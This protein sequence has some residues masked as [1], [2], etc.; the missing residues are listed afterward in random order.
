MTHKDDEEGELL[1][2]APLDR[3][4]PT[5]RAYTV[6]YDVWVKTTIRNLGEQP[7]T[8]IPVYFCVKPAGEETDRRDQVTLKS[9][10]EA[11]ME[12][13]VRLDQ[14]EGETET[15]WRF[16]DPRAQQEEER[17]R[18]KGASEASD[19]VVLHVRMLPPA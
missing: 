10:E 15:G 8:L 1:P 4:R 9:G 11:E 6:A 7:V 17:P 13:P 19:A 16:E 12:F 14:S 2:V 3:E 18:S 5:M